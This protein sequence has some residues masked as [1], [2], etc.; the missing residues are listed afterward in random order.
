[1]IRVNKIFFLLMCGV[2]LLC[3]SGCN[4][5]QNSYNTNEYSIDN[6]KYPQNEIR[7]FCIDDNEIYISS[8]DKADICKI[9]RDGNEIEHIGFGQG[10]H[11][12]LCMSEKKLYGFTYRDNEIGITEYDVIDKTLEFNPIAKDIT[13]VIA[14]TEVSGALYLIYWDDKHDEVQEGIKYDEDDDYIYMGEKAI[15]INLTNYECLDIE[16]SNV[17]NLKKYSDSEI[18]YY[19]Y[20]DEG[21]YYFTIYNT[22]DNSFS[23]K[24]YNNNIG[25]TFS[26]ALKD[27]QIL[28][29]DFA[30][31]KLVSESMYPKNG[32]IDVMANIVATSGNDLQVYGDDCFILDSESGSIFRIDYSK[33][34]HTN[35][36]IRFCSSEIYSEVP[37]GCGYNIDTYMLEDEE[38]ALKILAGDKDYDVCMM[39]YNQSFS[40]NIYEKGAFYPLNGL[41]KVEEYLDQCFPYLKDAA[42]DKNGNIWMIPIAVDVP[43]ILY[44]PDNCKKLGIDLS[45]D[46]SWQSLFDIAG[47]LYKDENMR[48]KYQ[49]NGYQMEANILRQYNSYY[50]LRD[51]QASYDTE[52]F[53]SLCNNLKK[54]DT[55]LPCFHTFIQ[56]YGAY[57][58]LEQYYDHFLFEL[59]S[60][61]YELNDPYPYNILRA[62]SFP[63]IDKE[64]PNCADC[65][66]LCVNSNSENLEDTLDFINTYCSYMMSRND[67]FMFKDTSKY[68]YSD[69]QLTKDLYEI[70]QDSALVFEASKKTFWDDYNRFSNDEITMEELIE[71]VERKTDMYMNE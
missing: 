24:I 1:M 46:V 39:S 68:P 37:F 58:D 71:E 48:D 7:A 62:I 28:Y 33:T 29:S 41:P 64:K 6:F 70:Y 63:E 15:S 14:M 45:E 3:C 42:Y 34:V 22:E 9:D 66:F 17:I 26:F 16:I 25:Y 44:N 54:A 32:A 51:G 35:E 20:D 60:Y 43:C 52:L 65:I 2:M 27:D 8:N 10:L 11:S 12:N 56:E 49:L 47:R 67:T 4:E 21:G 36:S 69:S 23:N 19:A 61:K 50:A 31:R 40:G 57:S 53:K 55:S 38:F 13:S 59:L 5:I 18:I 30:N